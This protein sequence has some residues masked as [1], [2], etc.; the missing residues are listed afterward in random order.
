MYERYIRNVNS[1]DES[2]KSFLSNYLSQR[3]VKDPK[4]IPYSKLYAIIKEGIREY[5][6]RAAK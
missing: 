2:F 5:L 4:A 6:K 1:D 3:G